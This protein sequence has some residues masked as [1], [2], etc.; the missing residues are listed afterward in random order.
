MAAITVDL[1]RFPLAVRQRMR[2]IM[3]REDCAKLAIAKAEQAKIIHGVRNSVGPGTTKEGIGPL[4]WA[5]HPYFVSYFRRLY[6][7]TIFSDPDFMK[8]LRKVGEWFHVEHAATKIQSGWRPP[9]FIRPKITTARTSTGIRAIK[10][11]IVYN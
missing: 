10:E 7:E 8:Y 11:R 9:P 4:A 2:D 1:T 3:H 5:F 6:G